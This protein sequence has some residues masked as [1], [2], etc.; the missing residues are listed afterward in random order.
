MEIMAGD[1]NLIQA[2]HNITQQHVT[3][4]LHFHNHSYEMMLVKSGHITYFIDHVAYRLESGDVT[5]ISPGDLH[6]LSVQDESTYE[7][8]PVHFGRKV[9]SALC[10]SETDLLECFHT[11]GKKV[12]HLSEE[13]SEEFIYYCNQLIRSLDTK[14]FGSDIQQKSCLS[15]LLILI[16][17]AYTHSPMKHINVLPVLIKNTIQY[18]EKHLT[19]DFS[20][21]D[22]SS[23]LNISRSRLMHSFKEKTGL[24][25]WN[26]VTLRRIS[27]AKDLIQGGKSITEACFESGFQDYGHFIKTFRKFNEDTTP[28]EFAKECSANRIIHEKTEKNADPAFPSAKDGDKTD[29]RRRGKGTGRSRHHE[30]G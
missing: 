30:D 8:Y 27:R 14:E 17:K 18:I 28:G 25:V 5:L 26:Y 29:D 20:I 24:S 22:M 11:D 4:P 3:Y 21:Q 2:S 1:I 13:E 15:L 9:G 10:S 19:E 7:R 6:G 12:C 23:T 16:N